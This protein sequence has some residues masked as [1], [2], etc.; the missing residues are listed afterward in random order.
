[1]TETPS[2]PPAASNLRWAG[3]AC[4]LIG[5]AML[6]YTGVTYRKSL[7]YAE[8]A[9]QQHRAAYEK[10]AAAATNPLTTEASKKHLEVVMSLTSSTH[11]LALTNCRLK[12]ALLGLSVLLAGAGFLLWFGTQRR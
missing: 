11:Q 7:S 10:H 8:Q 5:V 1:M 2:H 12:M 4:V 3:L 6:F 9:A